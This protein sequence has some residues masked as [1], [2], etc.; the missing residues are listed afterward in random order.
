MNDGLATPRWTDRVADIAARWVAHLPPPSP[1]AVAPPRDGG[2]QPLHYREW[3][4]LVARFGRSDGV[5]YATFGRVRRL[6]E[7]HLDRLSDAR[8]AE[9]PS[10]DAQL[11]FYLNAYNAI[12]IYQII[13]HYPLGSI[14]DIGTAFARP[15]PVGPENLTLHQLLHAKIRTF[16][17]PRVHAAIVPAARG[18]P[19]LRAYT[20]DGLDVEL[21]QQLRAYL[22][23]TVTANVQGHIVYLTLPAVVRWYMAD[24]A[25]PTRQQG[26]ADILPTARTEE[27]AL[28]FLTPYLPDDVRAA[29]VG[30][31]PRLAY[32]T[33]DWSL[34]DV[35]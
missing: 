31:H 11:A 34:N 17:D 6:L 21:D 30:H 32:R 10:R 8:P 29:L 9:W 4:P 35:R 26:I 12:A 5:E 25:S 27:A 19:S 24:F 23:Q 1:R 20:P 14:H 22:Q 13:L 7:S 2:D 28:D 33:Y 18:G 16:G 3:E 15:Y